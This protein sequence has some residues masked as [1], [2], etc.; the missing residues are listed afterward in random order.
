MGL[1]FWKIG[2]EL[3]RL[4]AQLGDLPGDLRSY[5]FATRDYDRRLRGQVRRWQ[6]RQPSSARVAIYLIF[7]SVG[8]RPSHLL[9]L[10]YLRRKGYAASVVSNCP[11]PPE[12]REEVLGHCHAY[13][14]R[15]NVGYD[16]G[17]YRDAVLDLLPEL[18]S[19]D[20]LVF[21]NDSTW[22]PLPGARDWLD[23]VEA[24]GVDF[25]GAASNYGAERP[26]IGRYRAIRWRYGTGHR[27]FH[28][29][30]FALCLRAEVFRHPDFPRFWRRLPLTD[31][32]RRTVRRGEIGFTQWALRHGFSNGCTLD[33]SRLDA[34]LAA[35]SEARLRELARTLIIPE[36]TRL[37]ALRDEVLRG[38]PTRDALIP[39]ILTVVARQGPAYALA[40][41]AIRDKG[42]P[43]LKKSPLWLSREGS[44]VTLTLAGDL[45]GEDGRAVAAEAQALRAPRAPG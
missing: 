23:D 8:L 34:E 12:Q 37:R 25:A 20:R 18:R 4:G 24:L 33:I 28:Y 10:D 1:S 36:D 3:R 21:L 29:A 43:F 35:L 13:M 5:F 44:D 11:L 19:L 40:A 42:F 14:E 31:R 39:L 15:P 22:F 6:G 45:A 30:S 7:P 41:Y 26:E 27:N 16:F 17:G 9:A 2:R 32:K 38:P